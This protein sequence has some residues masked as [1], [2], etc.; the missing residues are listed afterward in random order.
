MLQDVSLLGHIGKNM[1]HRL[2]MTDEV[3]AATVIAYPDVSEGILQQIADISGRNAVPVVVC[4]YVVKLY[5]L[6]ILEGDAM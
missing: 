4:R 6:R 2:C 3:Y 1:E 5:T